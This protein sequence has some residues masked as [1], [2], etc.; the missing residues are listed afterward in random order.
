MAPFFRS[1]RNRVLAALGLLGL[2]VWLVYLKSTEGG[3]AQRFTV[4]GTAAGLEQVLGGSAN[5]RSW[6]TP[7]G[8]RVLWVLK[9]DRSRSLILDGR[10]LDDDHGKIVFP[11]YPFSFVFS[12]D[13]MHFAA[14]V[15]V[16][17]KSHML[18]DGVL[19]P[20]FDKIDDSGFNNAEFQ[21]SP[22]SQHYAY[23]GTIDGK[24]Q[25]VRDNEPA[26]ELAGRAGAI[27]F[28]PDSKRL[29]C[30]VFKFQPGDRVPAVQVVVDGQAGAWHRWI[31]RFQFSADSRSFFYVANELDG[32]P[33]NP[34]QPGPPAE[35]FAHLSNSELQGV[36]SVFSPT[37]TL[38]IRNGETVATYPGGGSN[39][40]GKNLF[41]P[42]GRRLAFLL[43]PDGPMGTKYSYVVDGV[44][45]PVFSDPSDVSKILNNEIERNPGLVINGSHVPDRFIPRAEFSTDGLHFAYLMPVG[46]QARLVLD[47]VLGPLYDDIG[48][49]SFSADG[50][51][52]DYVAAIRNRW[53]VFVGGK[54][55]PGSDEFAG[56]L[57]QNAPGG[58][59]LNFSF[60]HQR[61]AYVTKSN[62]QY[63]VFHDGASGPVLERA[64]AFISF[65]SDGGRLAYVVNNRDKPDMPLG[66]LERLR[67]TVGFGKPV[68]KWQLYQGRRI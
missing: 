31:D 22:D 7:N 40:S 35:L 41:G 38:L 52:L 60:N 27:Y 32:A 30:W 65:S 16:D 44:A 53:R 13:G 50:A 8:L 24:E 19:G 56:R 25:L 14:P 29:A 18:V 9:D 67:E 33:T 55:L 45:G 1:T 57:S 66:W 21:F 42:D 46:N 17:G 23:F 64:P 28:S 6:A 11:Y 48:E 47:G 20:P 37:K 58:H 61:V 4:L 34:S 15:K 10:V 3:M 5:I 49:Y 59:M 39:G 43:R 63:R 26:I 12:P 36:F 54:E 51:H 2:A 68:G 62:N